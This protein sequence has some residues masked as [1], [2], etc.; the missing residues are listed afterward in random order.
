MIS[1]SQNREDV[2]LDRVFSDVERGFYIDVGAAH[3]TFHSVTRHFYDRGW[4]GINIEPRPD[5]YEELTE[6]R[7]RDVN[8]RAGASDRPDWTTLY[9]VM[10]SSIDATDLGG[11]STMDKDLARRYSD[12]GH[13]VTPV[14][15]KVLTLEQV[16]R[17]HDVAE[18]SFLKIDV[19]GYEARVIGGM[20]WQTY[21]PQ[22]VLIESTEPRSTVHNHE[23]WEKTLLDNGYCYATFD[24]LNRYYVRREDEKRLRRR[25]MTP[26]NVHDDYKPIQTV[27]LEIEIERLQSN[28]RR[29]PKEKARAWKRKIRRQTGLVFHR[30]TQLRLRQRI[31][32]RENAGS[33]TMSRNAPVRRIFLDCTP[34]SASTLNAGI[35]RV[36]RNLVR[37]CRATAKKDNVVCHPVNMAFGHYHR[38]KHPFRSKPRIPA[39]VRNTG[40]QICRFI[41][42]LFP[43]RIVQR[44][45]FPKPG[46]SGI[47]KIPRLICHKLHGLW[48]TCA[49]RV[50]PQEGDLIMLVDAHWSSK[51]L[52]PVVRS[53]K[54]RGAKVGAVIYDLIP[55][56]HPQFCIEKHIAAFSTWLQ[57]AVEHIDFFVCISNTVR[58]EV[59]KH[60]RL[61]ESS[62]PVGSFRLGCLVNAATSEGTVREQLKSVFSH[63]GDRRTYLTV[64]TLEPRKN[65]AY[66]LDAF[67][68]I[69]QRY[70]DTRLCIVGRVGWLCDDILHRITSHPRFGDALFLFDDLSDKELNYCYEH[71]K[72]FLFPS[73]V[74]GFGLPIVEAL[75]H[76]LP[77]LA[78]DIPVHREVGMDYCAY[79]DLSK[80]ESLVNM[81]M[82]LEAG[83][84][85]AG[86]QDPSGIE[87]LDWKGSTQ[88]FLRQCFDL[89][90]Q[91]Q[92]W[93][94]H[95]RSADTVNVQRSKQG[96]EHSETVK[97]D[98]A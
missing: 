44:L 54:A 37:E 62:Q 27:N 56:T 71:A 90:D 21:R 2:L 23:R 75:H 47:L 78:S 45:L 70:P 25:L 38:L 63:T 31:D 61:A 43:F 42:A 14:P 53:A 17:H 1:Y 57:A 94:S 91:S 65:H 74:E 51:D 3:P 68:R 77:V 6:H 19:E 22:V 95:G 9:V 92:H 34:T 16:C 41:Y 48:L 66:L 4:S 12:A 72:A 40:W 89:Y 60:V 80:P 20:D 13:H 86:V 26:V 82:D 35:Q 87:W 73:F 69:W 8:L 18:I 33:A 59:R 50:R 88:V 98:A 83:R 46:H 29:S 85:L 96:D 30:L 97:K 24:G 58:D 11:L 67:E 84:P 49:R 36:V 5:M 55:L 81:I 39:F 93:Q 7:S 76:H 32:S 10:V 15:T 52:W 28:Q 79:F 64:L